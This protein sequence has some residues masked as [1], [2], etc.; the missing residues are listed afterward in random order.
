MLVCMYIECVFPRPFPERHR[1]YFLDVLSLASFVYDVD[2]D[3]EREREREK[4]KGYFSANSTRNRRRCRYIGA[5][6]KYLGRM[7]GER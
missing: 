5:L 2:V 6:R 3:D 4:K 7:S 1:R